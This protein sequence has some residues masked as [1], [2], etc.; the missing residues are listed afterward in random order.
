[1][2]RGASG[3]LGRGLTFIIRAILKKRMGFMTRMMRVLPLSIPLSTLSS[4]CR[5]C[6]CEVGVGGGC[7]G[8][9]WYLCHLS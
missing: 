4:P 3:Q 2:E 8:K 5:V 9:R 6:V 1:M 7:R